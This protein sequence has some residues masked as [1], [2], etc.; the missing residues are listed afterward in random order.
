VRVDVQNAQIGVSQAR[1]QYISAQ[2]AQ[3]LQQQTLDA[4]QKKLQLGASTI[5]NVIL[6]ERDLVT[7]QSNLL[8][9]ESGYAKARVEL[10]RSTGQI[11]Y[12]ND[13]SMDEAVK[14]VVSRPANRIPD[15]PGIPQQPAQ[16]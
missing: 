15:T 13:V 7:A 9:A 10:D 16:K 6:A 5:Y 11:L 2:K 8:S 1:A 12:N 4:E 14:G 3:V